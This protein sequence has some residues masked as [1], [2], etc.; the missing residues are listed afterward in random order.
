MTQS[1]GSTGRIFAAGLALVCG[2]W[3]AAYSSRAQIAA[4]RAPA[5]FGKITPEA[6]VHIEPAALGMEANASATFAALGP[7]LAAGRGPLRGGALGEFAAPGG[8]Q[9]A[10]LEWASVPA[11]PK[12]LAAPEGGEPA[13]LIALVEKDL[14]KQHT[15]SAMPVMETLAEHMG[16]DG[17]GAKLIEDAPLFAVKRQRSAPPRLP[18]SR[19]HQLPHP[20]SQIG[21]A[22]AVLTDEEVT[23][24]EFILPFAS[25]RVTSLFND[26]RR[27][28]AIDLAGKL[29]SPVSATTSRQKVVFAGWRG[30]YGNAVI[31]QDAS[32]RTHL[33]GHLRSI[34]AR[35]GQMLD[36][37]EKLGHL[38]STG[39]ST[40]PHVHYEVRNNKG[41]HINPMLLLFAGRHVGKGYAWADPRQEGGMARVAARVR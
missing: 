21:D 11:L 41:A 30:G 16:I 32:G 36:Q 37:G 38:G 7:P 35:V 12:P 31:T 8:M 18:M 9:L 25:G 3:A 6:V 2:Y 5:L 40:G 4:I 24:P 17:L 15:G 14:K 39:H 19:S 20:F 27:H 29:G 28:P 1:V 13:A 23:A 34:T 33:Y 26:G 22:L 10:S